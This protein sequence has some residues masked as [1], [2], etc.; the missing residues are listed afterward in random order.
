MQEEQ[1]EVIDMPQSKIIG[2]ISE[3]AKGNYSIQ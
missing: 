3:V 1:E 2:G